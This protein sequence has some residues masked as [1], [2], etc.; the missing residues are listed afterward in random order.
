MSEKAISLLSPGKLNLFLHINGQREDGYHELQSVFQFFNYGDT[1]QFK[2]TPDA[3]I[4]LHCDDPSLES[5]DNLVLKA[6]EALN[7]YKTDQSLG[8]DIH[9]CKQLPMGGGVG[10]GSSNAATTLLAL[11]KL[12]DLQ[13]SIDELADIGLTLGADVPVFVRGHCAF[14][15]GVGEKIL[16][17][18]APEKWYLIAHPNCH[19]STAQIFTHPDLPR[20]TPKLTLANLD[21]AELKNDC[22]ELVKNH[23][24]EVAITL[25]WLL[26]YA[27]AKMTGTGAC[28]FAEFDDEES[29]RKALESKPEFVTSFI[30]KGLNI[31]PVHK[32][33]GY[34]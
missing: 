13:L 9:L 6:A 2:A 18:D 11:N 14:A 27:P 24:S 5:E 30:A 34:I 21:S 8:A 33:L 12:W 7:K 16:P 29:A 28:C 25:Q 4:S 1:L 31:S 17:Y 22:E 10:G 20:N 26:E 32:A 3:T 19:I 15:E 23:Y